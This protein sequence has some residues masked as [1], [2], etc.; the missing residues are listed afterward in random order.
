MFVVSG[1]AAEGAFQSC[2]L[3]PAGAVYIVSLPPAAYSLATS[4]AVTAAAE[5]GERSA[6]SATPPASLLLQCSTHPSPLLSQHP[7]VCDL[8]LVRHLQSRSLS[9]REP[10]GRSGRSILSTDA[11]TIRFAHSG[12]CMRCMC[13]LVWFLRALEILLRIVQDLLCAFQ[14]CI[15]LGGEGQGGSSTR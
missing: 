9:Q 3:R 10:R 6:R 8:S 11:S 12:A 14:A 5:A 1:W 15:F 2:R 4:A 7:S 13:T